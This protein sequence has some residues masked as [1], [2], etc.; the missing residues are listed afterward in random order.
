ML[1]DDTMG[2]GAKV[3]QKQSDE[4]T[5]LNVFKDLLGRLNGKSE[6][7]IK[8]EQQV[9]SELKT[10]LYVERKFGPMRF[11]KGGML[12]GDKITDVLKKED[13]VKKESDE[14]APKLETVPK[15][16]TASES[17]EAPAPKKEKKEKKEKKSK[18]RKANDSDSLDET[19]EKQDKR[20]KKKKKSR[21]EPAGGVTA[22]AAVPVGTHEDGKEK[23]SKKSKKSKAKPEELAEAD[24]EVKAKSKKSKKQKGDAAD[25]AEAD[26]AKN[27]ALED[28]DATKKKKKRKT[29]ESSDVEAV[30]TP[31]DS[32]ATPAD[33]GAST[34]R[35]MSARH[36]ARSRNIASKKLAMADMAALN[37]VRAHDIL[38]APVEQRRLIA[39]H[40]DLHGE[41]GV[42]YRLD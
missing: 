29:Q 10:S 2:L 6:D 27:S 28:T 32:T 18:K 30:A 5:G 3:R 26:D 24:G 33:S 38:I 35:V 9:R 16:E 15:L 22:D 8:Q 7:I 12:V 34:P 1:K 40:L 42:A 36:Y 31:A 20:D 11:V 25:L 17:D 37:Q 13:G 23:K 14:S 19:D 39:R 21:D 4:C 41:T